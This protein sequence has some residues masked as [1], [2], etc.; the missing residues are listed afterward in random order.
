M[1]LV[2]ILGAIVLLA[3]REAWFDWRMRRVDGDKLYVLSVSFALAFVGSAGWLLLCLAVSEVSLGEA[4]DGRIAQNL[5]WLALYTCIAWSTAFL[6]ILTTLRSSRAGFLDWG[7]VPVFGTLVSFIFE[8]ESSMS[9]PIQWFGLGL[10]L[11]GCASVILS[12][13]DTEDRHEAWWPK[14]VNYRRSLVIGIIFAIVAAFSGVLTFQYGRELRLAGV[15]TAVV[16]PIRILPLSPMLLL[17]SFLRGNRD[18]RISL[19]VWSM[20]VKLALLSLVPLYILFELIASDTV[21]VQRIALYLILL[22]VFVFLLGLRPFRLRT[23][24]AVPF[25]ER[26]GIV[27]I[28]TGWLLSEM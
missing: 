7:M 24:S 15:S 11:A 18:W 28:V 13:T 25:R 17:A 6:A 14:D 27:G 1:E 9:R 10:L 21:N 4:T 5:G 26:L 20:S 2:A 3:Y 12:L 19:P 8:G 16:M 22:P 23:W